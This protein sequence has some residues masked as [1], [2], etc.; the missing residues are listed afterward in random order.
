MS[1]AHR[2]LAR[3]P[4]EVFADLSL[5][6]KDAAGLRAECCLKLKQANLG[7]QVRGV[8]LVGPFCQLSSPTLVRILDPLLT[9]EECEEMKRRVYLNCAPKPMSALSLLGATSDSCEK[10][11]SENLLR[12]VSTGMPSLDLCLRGGFRVGTI[13]EIVGRAGTGKSQLAMQLCVVAASFNQGTVFIDTERKLSLRRLYEIA[14]ARVV[15]NAESARHSIDIDVGDDFM[16]DVVN[17][18]QTIE[19]VQAPL[20][21]KYQYKASRVVLENTSVHSPGSTI[22]LLSVIDGIE[23][24]I[25][26]R[27]QE[28]QESVS[29]FPVR[30]IVLDSIAAPAR[31]DFGSESAPQRVSAVMKAAQTLKRLAD[32]LQCAVVVINQVGLDDGGGESSD[33]AEGSDYVAVRAALGTSWHHCLTTRLLMEHERDPH[34]LNNTSDNAHTSDVPLGVDHALQFNRGHVRR[35]T[36]VKSNVAGLGNMNY[37]IANMGVVE[38]RDN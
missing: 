20:D 6:H 3:L 18:N 14:E 37:E 25:L 16:Y 17:D 12:H 15:A 27:N 24:E 4:L 26:H 31:R 2:S 8:T 34:R 23:E 22:E 19:S 9:F 30:L 7:L 35:A 29:K 36:V 33:R 32:Q 13:S 21:S 1:A 11:D 28:A 10:A 38:M 5:D